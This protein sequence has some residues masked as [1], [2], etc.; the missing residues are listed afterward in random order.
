MPGKD[1]AR[2]HRTCVHNALVRIPTSFAHQVLSSL[3]RDHAESTK[4]ELLELF[5][6]SSRHPARDTNRRVEP[7][8]VRG[9]L[10]KDDSKSLL[11]EDDNKGFQDAW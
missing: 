4:R 1:G 2:V 9:I 5:A 6:G 10:A 3:K 8:S 7:T 11:A